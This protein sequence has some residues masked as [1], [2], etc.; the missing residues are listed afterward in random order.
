MVVRS[1]HDLREDACISVF[2]EYTPCCS[3][4]LCRAQFNPNPHPALGSPWASTRAK[5]EDSR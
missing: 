5:V 1:R 2:R 4:M 3:P